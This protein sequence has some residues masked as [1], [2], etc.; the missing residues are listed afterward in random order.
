VKDRYLSTGNITPGTGDIPIFRH[1]SSEEEKLGV[2]GCLFTT[3]DL[4]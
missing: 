4:V 3:E 1:L 2:R